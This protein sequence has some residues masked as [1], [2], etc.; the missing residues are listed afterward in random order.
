M[1][2]SFFVDGF[3][4]APSWRNVTPMSK[5]EETLTNVVREDGIDGKATNAQSAWKCRLLCLRVF[6][7]FRVDSLNL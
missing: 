6:R 4:T 7:E 5:G 1:V 3:F 2:S